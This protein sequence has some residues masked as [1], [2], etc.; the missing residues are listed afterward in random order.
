M[1][2]L[3]RADFYRIFRGKAIYVTFVLMIIYLLLQVN[4]HNTGT[5]VGIHFTVED[6]IENIASATLTGVVAAQMIL[7]S[8]NELVF[9]LLPLMIA[10]AMAAFS[11]GAVKNEL[12]TG[13]SRPLFCLSKWL[14]SAILCTAFMLVYVLGAVAIGIASGGVG[15]LSH[16]VLST[17]LSAFGMQLLFVLAFNSLGIF[18]C[19]V[20][21]K[22]AVVTAV[23]VAF[24]MAPPMLAALLHG[25]FPTFVE[26][27]I[28]YDLWI[29]FTLF[30]Q[31]ANRSAVDI[32]RGLAVGLGYAALL[33]AAGIALFKRAEIK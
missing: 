12:S 30:A 10:V 33:L 6:G 13:L 28:Y 19:L 15:D 8:I 9:F 32:A 26:E 22:S 31:M 4:A 18:L 3:M 29:Q 14:T 20:T 24:A 5:N 11:S 23:F 21:R 7:H 17:I 1:V 25:V 2:R 27:Y 16:G